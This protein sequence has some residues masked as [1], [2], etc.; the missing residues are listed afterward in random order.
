[1]QHLVVVCHP[2]RQ[3]FIQSIAKAYADALKSEGHTVVVRDLYRARFDPALGE[4][5]LDG[6]TP[7]RIR[8]EQHHIAEAGAIA[9]FFP[10][11]WGYMP[12]MLKGYI[13]R[14]FAQGFAYEAD[15]D[16][17]APLL[18]GKKAMVF[19]SSG[20]D[21]PYLRRSKQWHAM[22]LLLD[23]H[24]LALCG[25]DMLEHVHFASITPALA[26]KTVAKHL[27]RVRSAVAHYWAGTAVP[28]G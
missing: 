27:T 6:R 12:A 1:M 3:S 19:S 9:L 18:S 23:D 8:R 5:E 22:R 28:A 26:E 25:I 15:A 4:A 13:D 11:W 7:A 24:F 20:A 17:M 21:M 14:V 10:V 16:D 2:K